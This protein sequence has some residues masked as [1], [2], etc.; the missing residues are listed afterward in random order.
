MS[1][2]AV[3]VFK[4]DIDLLVS[5]FGKVVPAQELT[6]D[7]VIA[8]EFLLEYGGYTDP[9]GQLASVIMG[10][11]E[12]VAT[13]IVNSV[14]TT[15]SGISSSILNAISNATNSIISS[16]RSVLDSMYSWLRSTL[17]TISSNLSSILT[18][19][20]SGISSLSYAIS[21]AVSS[22]QNALTSITKLIQ[23]ITTAVQSSLSAVVSTVQN[24]SNTLQSALQS[25]VNTISSM[26]QSVVQGF[27][28]TVS[29]IQSLIT[30][31]QSS[32]ANIFEA[33]SLIR[34][35]LINTL[36]PIS[37]AISSIATTIPEI[38]GKLYD[39]IKPIFDAIFEKIKDIPEKMREISV[40]F[41]GFINPLVTIATLFEQIYKNVIDFLLNVPNYLRAVGDFFATI[42]KD[43]LG[44]FNKN[45][46]KPLSDAFSALGQW[47]WE[48]L[49][50]WLRNSIDAITKTFGEIYNIITKTLN[51]IFDKILAFFKD[52]IGAVNA[53]LRD[54][55]NAVTGALSWVYQGIIN[56]LGGLTNTLI[57]AIRNLASTLYNGFVSV[58]S[59]LVKTVLSGFLN[60][61]RGLVDFS[62]MLWE[63]AGKFVVNLISTVFEKIYTSVAV[64]IEKLFMDV[65]D[66]ILKRQERGQLIETTYLMGSMLMTF[67][68]SEYLSTGLQII[69]KKIGGFLNQYETAFTIR[70]RGSGRAKGSPVGVGAEAGGDIG[71]DKTFTMRFNLG[72]PFMH[73]AEMMSNYTDEF[74]RGMLYGMTIWIT[75]PISKLANALWRNYLPVELPTIA[76]M[77]EI[78]RRH[79]PTER[80]TELLNSMRKYLCLYGYND[81]VIGWLTTTIDTA[82][83]SVEFYD[84]FGIRRRAPL[85]LLYELPT[86]SDLSR[87][88]IRDIFSVPGKPE[89]AMTSF[90][91]LMAMKGYYEDF[92]KLYYLLHYKYPSMS[93]LWTFACRV[94]AKQPWVTEEPQVEEDLGAEKA[95][96]P[97]KLMSVYGLTSFTS[98]DVAKKLNDI[99]GKV[100]KHYAKW[101]DYAPFAWLDGWTADNL[102]YLDLMADI[103]MRIDARWMYKWSVPVSK[104]ISNIT[105]SQYFDE[106]ALFLIVVSRGMHP[107]WV[108]P[109]TI[110]ECMNALQEERT[111]VRTGVLNMYKEG[112]MTLSSL[113]NTL[114]HLTTVNI[115]GKEVPV[116]FIDGEVKLLTLRAKYDRAMDILK[117]YFKDLLRGVEQ[118]IISFDEMLTSLREEVNEIARKLGLTALSLDNEYY[119]LYEPITKVLRKLRIVER[120]R[121]WYRYMLYRLLYRFSEG[122]MSKEEF[123]DI[124]NKITLNANLTTEEKRALT[125]IA[126]LMYDGFYRKT[127]ADGILNKV[128][129]GAIDPATAKFKLIELGLSEDLAD[130]LIEKNMKVHSLSISTI[131]S[132]AEYIDIPEDFVKKKLEWMG[133]PPDEVPIILQVFRIR[134][135][136]DE[137]AKM[138]RSL[139]DAY[140]SGYIT[141]DLFQQNLA[142]MGK[143]KR[144]IEILTEFADFERSQSAVKMFIDAILNRLRR[145]AI[146]LEQAKKELEKY[147]M[148]KA[149]IDAMIEKYVRTS[150]WSPDKLVSMAEYVSVDIQKLVEK[151]KMFGYPD[152]EVNL[153]PAYLLAKNLSEEIKSIVNELIYLYVYDIIDENALRAEIDRVRTLNGE[154]KKFGVDWIVID[155][156]EREL[157]INRAKL[158]KIRELYK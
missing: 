15:L 66:R 145:G 106:K 116:R 64:P 128:R 117:D 109:I 87:M 36:T 158:R 39:F 99:V 14:K 122:Y 79:I 71:G 146:T 107:K 51:V 111:Y 30:S 96:S 130:A 44:W 40:A 7:L 102:I 148:D 97:V 27:K 31:I 80:F 70:V 150:V 143:S 104:E 41:Q 18:V 133:V 46:V 139:I 35:T 88:M 2:E 83:W 19:L 72:Y 86:P 153:Y 68:G 3:E 155:D 10:F 81:E 119:T 47:I 89:L 62:H 112:F 123:N 157:I 125:E 61:V 137:M 93:D 127:I 52:P 5:V 132:Y 75:Q 49:P 129:R 103:P 144:E 115:L 141:K 101:H 92:A 38:P 63:E 113:S 98:E 50:D 34:T 21:S 45:I 105:G 138:I 85:S 131:I 53:F 100:L 6:L 94:V 8:D 78:T 154:V 91:T 84:R 121:Y 118:N 16:L 17:S 126:E 134:P 24:I 42:V 140:I 4:P 28:Y 76:E 114:S 151:A 33:L 124:I 60:V 120:I 55:W 108:E 29:A 26:Y 9:L 59:G 156:V 57:G 12:D 110:A 73:L 82:G 56:V 58:A 90:K 25:V 11:I 136:K 95:M 22:I 149:L 43:P 77:R 1:S 147:V 135:L 37:N 23:G 65:I 48:K 54:V 32:L 13:Y 152:D 67:I 74:R 69:F 142:N 20:Q